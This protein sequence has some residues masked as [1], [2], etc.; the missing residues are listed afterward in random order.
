MRG[1]SGG[2]PIEAPTA[3]CGDEGRHSLATTEYA[4]ASRRVRLTDTTRFPT[5]S[6]ESSMKIHIASLACAVIGTLACGAAHA[7][8]AAPAA[9]S[10][11]ALTGNISAV[12]DYLFR[13]ISQ[14]SQDPALQ[15][16]VEYGSAD[17]WYIG[18][19]GSNVSW[20]SDGST[21]DARISN[22]LEVDVYAGWR[23]PLN[24]QWKLDVGLYTYYYPGDY[25][26]GFTR[27]YTTEAYAGLS[28]SILTLKYSHAFTNTFGFADSK[29][30]DYLD[31]SANWEFVP[32]WVLNGHVGRQ[33][34]KNF[35]D[36]SYTDWKLGVT[37]NF[38]NGISVALGYY[39]TN[40]K[41]SVY[42]NSE[43][44]FLGRS[45]GVLSVTK[46]F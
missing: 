28:W 3:G 9:P 38:A 36:A 24:D 18:A 43:G 7:D 29:H 34:I 30:S 4:N 19:W 46:A 13:G 6:G 16:G 32:T 42:T 33:R 37:R 15:G 44:E 21:P 25:P 14:T 45:T 23:I 27:P 26:H 1:G 35:D 39:D 41:E 12:S 5:R 31:L 11:P 20:L 8:D 17:S 2:A 10:G 22:S 40:A